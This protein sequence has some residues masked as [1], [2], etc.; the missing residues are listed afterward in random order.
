MVP[1]VWGAV[2][3]VALK[4]GCLGLL[5]L[6]TAAVREDEI[7]R[8]CLVLGGKEGDII[9]TSKVKVMLFMGVISSFQAF[10]PMMVPVPPAVKVVEQL[11]RSQK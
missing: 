11:L 5:F 6:A 1:L 9:K 7:T 2:E 4:E 8:G 3:E 10:S